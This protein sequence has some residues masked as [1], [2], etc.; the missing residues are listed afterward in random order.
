[1]HS[2]EILM[3][4]NNIFLKNQRISDYIL[5]LKIIIGVSSI[6]YKVIRTILSLFIFL[7]CKKSRHR[8]K[9]TNK[10]KTSKH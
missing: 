7:K 5:L 3:H 1:M 4:Q 8:Q 6:V 10:T 2:E 9:P